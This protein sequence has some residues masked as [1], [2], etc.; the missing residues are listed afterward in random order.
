MNPLLEAF[1][2]YYWN[3]GPADDLMVELIDDTI[4]QI[5]KANDARNK[6][7]HTYF[8]FQ[9][10]SDFTWYFIEQFWEMKLKDA[11][12]ELICGQDN[13]DKVR[14]TVW[15]LATQFNNTFFVTEDVNRAKDVL[16]KILNTLE[17]AGMIEIT[18]RKLK[19]RMRIART[20]EFN[21]FR[22]NEV[23]DSGFLNTSNNASSLAAV[24]LELESVKQTGYFDLVKKI[25]PF[26]ANLKFV[27]IST[28]GGS[29]YDPGEEEGTGNEPEGGAE[30]L[31]GDEDNPEGGEYGSENFSSGSEKLLESLSNILDSEPAEP[32]DVFCPFR[33][34]QMLKDVMRQLNIEPD[35][36]ANEALK[37]LEINELNSFMLTL[38]LKGNG[39]GR[40]GRIVARICELLGISS[41]TYYD[42]VNRFQAVMTGLL[43]D[44]R[45]ASEKE[46][47]VSIVRMFYNVYKR[48]CVY[49]PAA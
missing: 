28:D 40:M 45:Y 15:F 13:D 25:S 42:K 32:E 48:K 24:L 7:F 23:F 31:S 22:A 3:N 6:G 12:L 2:A 19:R 43:E 11:G 1:R 20:S 27:F 47:L 16:D 33:N 5:V 44:E 4:Y 35:P 21:L 41:S 37:R 49:E 46:E 39:S 26:Y 8:G 18:N 36:V 10:K 29:G 30:I 9:D 14:S 17:E 34:K 38:I